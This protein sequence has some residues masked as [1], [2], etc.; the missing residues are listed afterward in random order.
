MGGAAGG[1]I[2]TLA[3]ASAFGDEICANTQSA[4]SRAVRRPC[5]ISG[6]PEARGDVDEASAELRRGPAVSP[7]CQWLKM[8]DGREKQEQ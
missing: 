3:L 2:S 5:G 4:A 7:E 8:A 1:Q 6:T